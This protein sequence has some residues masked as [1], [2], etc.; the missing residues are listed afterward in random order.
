VVFVNI[1]AEKGLLASPYSEETVFQS[2][3]EGT[4]PKEHTPRP[5]AAKSGQFPQFDM[6]FAE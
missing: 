6:D 1:D 2:F 4:E 5:G 3:K